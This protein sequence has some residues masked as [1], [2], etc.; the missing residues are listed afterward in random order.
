MGKKGPGTRGWHASQAKVKPGIKGRGRTGKGG[1]A[2]AGGA[3]DL[4]TSVG[5]AS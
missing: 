2:D 4:G 5:G 3:T 1:F